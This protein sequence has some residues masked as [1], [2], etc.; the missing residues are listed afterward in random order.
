MANGGDAAG[1]D[2]VHLRDNAS[3]NHPLSPTFTHHSPRALS[4]CNPP[5]GTNFMHLCKR[6]TITEQNAYTGQNSD[7]R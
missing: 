2:A 3:G 5:P 7:W 6:L 1:V 4:P